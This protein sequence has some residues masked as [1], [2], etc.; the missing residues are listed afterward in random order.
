MFVP[1]KGR[2]L[3]EEIAGQIREAVMTGQLQA[4][5]R[6]PPE[7]ELARIF[8]T[9]PLV[10]RDALHTLESDGLLQIRLGALGGAVVQ[11]ASHRSVTRSLATLLR[12][13]KATMDQLTEAR[14]CLEPE[15]A[16]LAASRATIEDLAALERALDERRAAVRAG[17][18]PRLH[19]IQFH[20]LI[21]EAARNPVHLVVV[22]ALM[23]LEA[24]A[25]VP[26]LSLTAEDNRQ[27]LRAH[28]G[29][30]A[31]IRAGNAGEARR[32]MEQH[33]LDVQ[34]RLESLENGRPDSRRS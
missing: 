17:A 14:L 15:I 11:E 29:I 4:G 30:L 6:L 31:A 22:H 2:R 10:V 7:R 28:Q 19:D 3:S 20:R 13:T 24:E 21:A 32:L 33:V 12:R 8:G 9:S 34:Q 27:V 25:V 26:A 1:V 5:D 16:R 18:H 23:D